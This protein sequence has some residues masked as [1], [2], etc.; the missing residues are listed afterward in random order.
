MRAFTIVAL[1][2]LFALLMELDPD[3]RDTLDGMI[4]QR[5]RL[6]LPS[7][8]WRLQPQPSL[9]VVPVIAIGDGSMSPHALDRLI[10]IHKALGTHPSISGRLDPLEVWQLDEQ[11]NRTARWLPGIDP[12]PA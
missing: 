3:A 4:A 10:E 1:T 6:G 11:G 2:F 7:P 9:R 8:S 5:H 12:K